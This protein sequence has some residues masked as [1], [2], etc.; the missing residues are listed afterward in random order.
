MLFISVICGILKSLRTEVRQPEACLDCSKSILHGVLMLR[1][2][3]MQLLLRFSS[4]RALPLGL[5]HSVMKSR[6]V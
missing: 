5:L 2:L 4:R 3:T 1:S 6:T